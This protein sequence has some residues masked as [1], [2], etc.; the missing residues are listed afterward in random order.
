MTI[1]EQP[2]YTLYLT[3]ITAK[4]RAG[5]RQAVE[6]LINTVFPGYTLDHDHYGAPFISGICAHISISHGAQTA[7]LAVSDN[8][9]GVDIEAPR[10]QLSRV[11]AKF[12]LP[13]DTYPSL[14]HA[15]TAKEATFKA[16]G[17]P[18]L[19]ISQIALSRQP[20]AICFYTTTPQQTRFAITYH[21][22][23]HGALIAVATPL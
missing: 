16:A 22:Q 1:I 2:N 7:V 23:P 19:T 12:I 15:W 17:N 21:P 9:I 4:A 6:T 14:L 13:H 20:D 18:Q 8:P 3:T 10:Q 11:A 5:E